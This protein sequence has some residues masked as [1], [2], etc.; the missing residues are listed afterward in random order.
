MNKNSIDV[1]KNITDITNN[2]IKSW[3]I[4]GRECLKQNKNPKK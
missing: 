2:E 4:K 1:V 3:K